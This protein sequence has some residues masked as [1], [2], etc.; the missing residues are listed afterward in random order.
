MTRS[1]LD[2]AVSRQYEAWP[3]PEPAADLDAWDA[4]ARYYP[5]PD[6]QHLVFWPDRGYP[7]GLDILIAG[8]GANQAASLARYNPT[9]RILG[10]DVSSASLASQQRLKDMHGLANLELRRLPIEQ[11]GSLGRDFDLI[12]STGVLHH[13]DDPDLGMRVLGGL[14][15]PEGVFSLM[16]YS[17]YGWYAV[18][19][20]AELCSLLGLDQS[21]DSVAVVRET[22]ARLPPHH[23]MRNYLAL[24]PSDLATDSGIVDSFLH[25]RAKTYSVPDILQMVERAGLRFQGWMSNYLYH[26]EAL[27]S[28]SVLRRRING[29]P[30]PE[31][32]AAMELFYALGNANHFFHVCRRD[33]PRERYVIDFADPRITDYIPVPSHG[34]EVTQ[35]DSG[36]PLRLRR[37]GIDTALDPAQGMAFRLVD[38]TRSIARIVADM[39][40]AGVEGTTEQALDFARSF[41]RALWRLELVYIRLPDRT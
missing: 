16:L 12:I 41:F 13:M 2:D 39:R 8:C 17:R 10:I 36:Q 26:P 35:D 27:P 18:R 37:R 25:P 19:V 1:P 28:D 21:A 31:M 29:L 9:A 38:G 23:P 32:W 30:E 4:K 40:D 34:L 5:D 7:P 20:L 24:G 6:I 33:R 15:R 3:Y 11:A 22:I 14:L